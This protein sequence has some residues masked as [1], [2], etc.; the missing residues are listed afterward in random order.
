[1]NKDF[2]IEDFTDEDEKVLEKI[3]SGVAADTRKDPVTGRVEKRGAK[4]ALNKRKLSK[5]EMDELF[6]DF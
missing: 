6:L 3:K 4:N 2:M 1:M 5:H